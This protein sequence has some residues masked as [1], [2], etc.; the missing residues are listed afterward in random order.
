MSV[1][2]LIMLIVAVFAGYIYF[3]Y[4]GGGSGQMVSD[5]FVSNDK[6]EKIVDVDFNGP[7]RY[8]GHF[9]EA[10]GDILQVKFR[11]I[12][13]KGDR[14]NYSLIDKLRLQGIVGMKEY[15]E[16]IRYEGD[17]PGGPFLILRFTKPVTFA[18]KE[19]GGLKGLQIRYKQL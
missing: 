13:Y 3:T 17:V 12:A 5:V 8:L 11:S 18:V 15:I 10:Q 9:P 4:L 6:N 1:K 14:D 7:V 16:D 2:S 19:S